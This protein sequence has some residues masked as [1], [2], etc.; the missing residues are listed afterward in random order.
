MSKASEKRK[1]G[2]E[3][4]RAKGVETN[5]ESGGEGERMN[6]LSNERRPITGTT[7]QET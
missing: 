1:D 6:D 5:A 3:T 7:T 4:E 2:R